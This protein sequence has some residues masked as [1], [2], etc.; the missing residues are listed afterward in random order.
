MSSAIQPT[1][2][3]CLAAN[4]EG[5]RG[6][7]TCAQPDSL[8]IILSDVVLNPRPIM[9]PLAQCLR[10]L[11]QPVRDLIVAEE[12]GQHR[13]LQCEPVF[14]LAYVHQVPLQVLVGYTE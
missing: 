10:V 3:W 11:M 9:V 2:Q 14:G 4:N 1:H 5:T 13:D 7:L 6:K 8:D 12:A